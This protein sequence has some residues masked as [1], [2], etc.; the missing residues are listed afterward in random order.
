MNE[1]VFRKATPNDAQPITDLVNFGAGEK[2][3][4]PR[5]LE[6]VR[7]S[8]ENWIIAAQSG[9]IVAVGSLFDL[10]PILAEVR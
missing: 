6:Y 4:L 9:R 1:I 7:A 8:I 5:S 10:S 2:Q 3:L